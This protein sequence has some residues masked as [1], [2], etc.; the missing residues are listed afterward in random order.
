MNGTS[1]VRRTFMAFTDTQ[2]RMIH[3]ACEASAALIRVQGGETAERDAQE[4]EEL[5]REVLGYLDANA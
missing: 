5:G 3:R 1:E 4:L 2:R